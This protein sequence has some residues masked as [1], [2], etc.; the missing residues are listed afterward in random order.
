MAPRK[1]KVNSPVEPDPNRIQTRTKNVTTHPG[2]I[3]NETVVRRSA[4]EFEAEKNAKEEW[5]RLQ[6]QKEVDLEAAA[7]DIAEYE[8][9]MAVD[10]AGDMARFPRSK[11]KGEIIPEPCSAVIKV[12]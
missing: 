12:N 2:K 9:K 7:V 1:P 11:T 8:N 10:D 6:K 5:R 4:E 3:I